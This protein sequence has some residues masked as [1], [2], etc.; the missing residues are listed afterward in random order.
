MTGSLI[1]NVIPRRVWDSRG[2]PTIEVDIRLD[3]GAMGRAIAPAGASRGSREAI[4][5]RDG[6][7]KLRGLDVEAAI[8][9]VRERIAPAL[10]GHDVSDQAGIDGVLIELD[11][12]ANKSSLG[13]NAMV[14]ASMAALHAAAAL[15]QKPLWMHV[16]EH[17]G[18]MPTVPLPEIQIFG[19]GAHAGRRVDVQD[20]MV[21]VPGAESF[22]EVMAV[23]AE[24]HAAGRQDHGRQRKVGRGRG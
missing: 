9:G 19:G 21:M 14:A 13:G 1:S 3:G 18:R 12:T 17:Y 5:L 2:N 15:E 11:G 20:F 23:T 22:D 24:I 10:I 6:G 7:Q 16:A 8:A 4:E